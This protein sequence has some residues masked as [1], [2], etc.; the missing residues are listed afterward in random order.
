MDPAVLRILRMSNMQAR[1]G[2]VERRAF[3]PCLWDDL[4]HRE[5][6]TGL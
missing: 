5:L 6:S 3:L 1:S 2:T 4:P